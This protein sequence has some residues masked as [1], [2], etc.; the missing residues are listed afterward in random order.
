MT[1]SPAELQERYNE[2][3]FLSPLPVLDETELREARD[4]FA[5]LEEEFGTAYTQYSLH[6]V[7]LQYPWVMSLT[8][9]PRILRVIQAILGPDVIL[10]DSRFICKYPTIKPLPYVA[11]HQDMRY[12]GIAGGPVLSVWLALDDSQKENGV[13]QVIPG[14]HCSG[15]LPH[16]QATRPGN[17]LSVN[18]EI[19]EELVQVDEAVLCP[20]KAGQMSIHDGLLV[21]ASDANTSQRRRCGFVIRYVPTCAH[22]TED[23]DRPR[24]FHATELVCGVDQFHHFSNKST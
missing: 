15:M 21:H 24:K 22:P 5:K 17:L 10:L 23:P 7:H 12:W 2:E 14:S 9:H 6:N 19:P 3:G 11:W 4:A 20:L 8:K 16:R 13:L 1:T 18:Q